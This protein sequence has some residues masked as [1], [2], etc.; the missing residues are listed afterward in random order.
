MQ[1]MF[2]VHRAVP[3][4]LLWFAITWCTAT[5]VGGSEIQFHPRLLAGAVSYTLF[6]LLLRVMDEFKD[7]ELDRRLFP[8]R[9]LVTGMVTRQD[10]MLLGWGTVVVLLLLNLWQ[11]LPIVGVFLICFAYCVLMFKFFFWPKV[12]ESLVLAVITH[13]PVALLF[14]FYAIS[15]HLEFSHAAAPLWPLVPVAVLFWLPWLAWE[16][17]RKIRAPASEDDYETYSKILGH[18]RAC[19]LVLGLV[20]TIYALTLWVA[21]FYGSWLLL[22][23][24]MGA[25]TVWVAHACVQFMRAPTAG[26]A[27]LRPRLEMYLLLFAS[28]WAVAQIVG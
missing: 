8:D 15:Y 18:R 16:V 2:P 4:C 14:Q 17:A 12:R 28:V 19:A 7:F 25:A 22:A 1:T 10:L 5:C 20:V 13:N 23:G 3:V 11:G 24:G 26:K 21:Q 27:P 6:Y 9:P